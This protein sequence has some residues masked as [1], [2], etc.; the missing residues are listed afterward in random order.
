MNHSFIHKYPSN[1]QVKGKT[2]ESK[3]IPKSGI[4][5]VE[6]VFYIYKSKIQFILMNNMFKVVTLI[7]H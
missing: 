1:V 3:W 7:Y 6:F 4:E 5:A 2:K